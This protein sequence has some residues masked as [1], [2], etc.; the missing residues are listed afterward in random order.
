MTKARDYIERRHRGA[1]GGVM[2][3]ST[4]YRLLTDDEVA[5]RLGNTATLSFE[6]HWYS[7]APSYYRGSLPAC[8]PSLWAVRMCEEFYEAGRRDERDHAAASATPRAEQS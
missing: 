8:D 2:A 7:L 6:A 1:R 3:A 4:N 5:Q